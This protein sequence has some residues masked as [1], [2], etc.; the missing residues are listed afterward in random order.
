MQSKCTL[1]NIGVA[2][3]PEMP[4]REGIENYFSIQYD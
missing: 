3:G 2:G 1:V 4:Y